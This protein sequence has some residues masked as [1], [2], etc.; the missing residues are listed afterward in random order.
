MILATLDTITRRGLLEAGLPIHYYLE[1]MIHGSTCLR[2]LSF[3]TLKIINTVQLPVNDY[4]AVDLPDDFVDEVSVGFFG[5]GTLQPLP[6]QNS[7][8][9][10]RLHDPTT[11]QYTSPQL[12]TNGVIPGNVN[13]VNSGNDLFLGGLGIF[14]FWNVSD[15]GEPTGRFFGATGGTSIGYKVIRE[16]RQIQMSNGYERKSVVLQYISDGQSIDSATQI[17]TQAIQTIRAW[18]EWKRSPTANNE[19]SAEAMSF[20]NRKKNLRARLSGMSLVDVKNALRNGYTA[21]VKN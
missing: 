3:D 11:G 20:W 14:W 17:D 21:A 1:Y 8:S 19:Y 15:F 6:H 12:P 5:G 13:N 18:Q 10:L 9:P 4:G 16:R 7:I 2:E